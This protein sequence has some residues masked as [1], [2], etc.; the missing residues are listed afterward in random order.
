MTDQIV[1]NPIYH[2]HII[3]IINAAPV[4]DTEPFALGV[5]LYDEEPNRPCK[6]F[7]KAKQYCIGL[8]L[9]TTICFGF[10]LFVGG[11]GFFV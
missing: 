1:I 3:Y 6:F 11:I 9:M 7:Y 4:N 10:F 2:E 8:C 5:L